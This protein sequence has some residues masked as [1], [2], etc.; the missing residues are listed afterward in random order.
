MRFGVVMADSRIKRSVLAGLALI[1]GFFFGTVGEIAY[2]STVFQPF[3]WKEYAPPIILNCYGADFSEQQLLRGI[4]YW[5]TRGFPIAFYEMKQP[6]KAC[7]EESLLG[8]IIL[9]KAFHGQIADQNLAETTR[10]TTGMRILSAEI[11][12]QPGS[13][14]LDLI[15][16]HELGHAFGLGHIE[17]EGHIMHPLYNRMGPSFWVP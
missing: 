10:K 14:N 3:G 11:V 1:I 17:K 6:P 2:E 15:I 13:Q 5:A 9:R 8:F 12:F 7:E 4:D 16:E